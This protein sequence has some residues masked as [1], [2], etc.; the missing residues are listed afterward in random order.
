MITSKLSAQ[1]LE[2]KEKSKLKQKGISI[3]VKNLRGYI[4]N[5]SYYSYIVS[6]CGLV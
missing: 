6:V 1:I 5:L 3:K 2:C 4:K